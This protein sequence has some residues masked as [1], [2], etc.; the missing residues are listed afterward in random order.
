M[1]RATVLVLFAALWLV[2]F[3]LAAVTAGAPAAVT[4]GTVG[5]A[6]VLA[7]TAALIASQTPS[8][9]HYRSR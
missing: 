8:P 9:R 4:L 1:T 3:G 6:G 5:L 7:S 2:G